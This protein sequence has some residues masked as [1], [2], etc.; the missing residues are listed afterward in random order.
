MFPKP[1]KHR[2]C[3]HSKNC[4]RSMKPSPFDFTQ[5][6]FSSFLQCGQIGHALAGAST[7]SSFFAISVSIGRTVAISGSRPSTNH[8]AG[9]YRES[10]A[11][12]GSMAAAVAG[13]ARGVLAPTIAKTN[14]QATPKNMAN[15][16]TSETAM[17]HL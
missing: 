1:R 17:R 2:Q 10:A 12:L 16:N 9:F 13:D 15:V 6:N 14:K 3:G 7:R 5:M 8:T 4:L 11:S